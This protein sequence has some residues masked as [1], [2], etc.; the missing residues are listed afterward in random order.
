MSFVRTKTLREHVV[1]FE[2]A[3]IL[4]TMRRNGRSRMKVA[5]ALGLTVRGL[6]KKMEALGMCRPRY[7]K[8]LPFGACD[9]PGDPD[10]SGEE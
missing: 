8:P 4:E 2:R 9:V 10:E 1:G 7:A 6:E 3:I 5:K